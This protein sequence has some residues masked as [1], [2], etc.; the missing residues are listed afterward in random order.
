MD[1]HDI[2]ATGK[3]PRKIL[4]VSV[5]A[6]DEEIRAAYLKKIKE[7]PPDRSPLE[8]ERIRDAY[9]VLRD[10]R[11]RARIM[12]QSANPESS[13]VLLVDSHVPE[14]RCVGP[15]PWLAAMRE[16]QSGT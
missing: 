15:K 8:F 5:D 12:L 11:R 2:M 9:D 16:R 7:F 1:K 14:R 10:P 4:G 13:L 3:D 6:S